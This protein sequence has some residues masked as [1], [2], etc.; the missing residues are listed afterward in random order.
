MYSTSKIFNY[1]YTIFWY[2]YHIINEKI[3][4]SIAD[5][6]KWNKKIT[7]ALSYQNLNNFLPIKYS[8]CTSAIFFYRPNSLSMNIRGY[9][10]RGEANIDI[11]YWSVYLPSRISGE[12]GG[13]N[14]A[15]YKFHFIRVHHNLVSALSCNKCIMFLQSWQLW[16]AD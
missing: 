3:W 11:I 1:F 13:V 6:C 12:E 16:P 10:D 4:L 7:T 15:S 2:I 8:D 9:Y 14:L 5:S